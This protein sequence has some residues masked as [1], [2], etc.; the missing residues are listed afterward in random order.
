MTHKQ[1]I[2]II[3]FF[4]FQTG[5]LQEI[6]PLPIKTLSLMDLRVLWDGLRN[7]LV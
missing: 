5:V 3:Y 2:N 1:Q 6:V 4:N 7:G